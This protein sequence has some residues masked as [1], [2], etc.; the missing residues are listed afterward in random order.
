MPPSAF[1]EEPLEPRPGARPTLRLPERV[2]AA[3]LLVV[4]AVATGLVVLIHYEGVHWLARRYSGRTP[5]R[6]S[7][8]RA[9]L[10]VIGE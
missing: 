5:E 10:K 6:A 2:A 8:R 1:V 3:L 7:D 4:A 9:I